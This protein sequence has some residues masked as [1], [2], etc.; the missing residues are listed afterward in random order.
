[1]PVVAVESLHLH[2][3]ADVTNSGALSQWKLAMRLGTTKLLH[4]LYYV[5]G[6]VGSLWV[7]DEPRCASVVEC[8]R[9]D[10]DGITR[11]FPIAA[12]A[13]VFLMK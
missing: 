6:G 2:P 5:V 13:R 9:Y 8:Y 11:V 3:R 1:M 12:Q 4:C 10:V 7:D